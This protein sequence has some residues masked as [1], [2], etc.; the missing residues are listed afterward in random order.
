[1]DRRDIFFLGAGLAAG[2]VLVRVLLGL[3]SPSV[4]SV[5]D[6]VIAGRVRERLAR[7]GADVEVSVVRGEVEL[8]G[9]VASSDH[10]RI[11]R[12]VARVRGVRTIDDDLALLEIGR[13][14]ALH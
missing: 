5:T 6:D 13:P 8:R 10:S 12:A 7:L 4:E 11:L 1:M 2:A 14:S 9:S 3:R